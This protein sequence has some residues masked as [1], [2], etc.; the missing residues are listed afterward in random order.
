MAHH[1]AGGRVEAIDQQAHFVIDGKAERTLDAAG[2]ALLQPTASGFKQRGEDGGIIDGFEK[3][4]LANAIIITRAAELANLSRDA[5]H[6]PAI[7]LGQK[8][9]GLGMLEIRVLLGV[10]VFEALQIERRHPMRV[11]AVDGKGQV[12]KRADAGLV[13]N[14]SDGDGITHGDWL[15]LAASRTQAWRIRL[16]RMPAPG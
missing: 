2:A 14:R 11:I 13:A 8:K 15:S 16:G 1:H 3:A 12:Q 7:L 4:E 5:A 6:R 10:K 9:F